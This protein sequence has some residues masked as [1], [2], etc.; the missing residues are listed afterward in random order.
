MPFRVW[1]LPYDSF[2]G[3]R[4]PALKRRNMRAFIESCWQ[5]ASLREKRRP[6]SLTPST[7]FTTDDETDFLT[8]LIYYKYDD[9]PYSRGYSSPATQ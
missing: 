1:A 9:R 8:A 2:K 4:Y 3:K 5:A 7:P 6:T